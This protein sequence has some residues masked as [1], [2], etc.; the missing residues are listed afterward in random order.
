MIEPGSGKQMQSMNG[1]YK[2]SS[3]F[4]PQSSQEAMRTSN[5]G[6]VELTDKLLETFKPALVFKNFV[7][8]IY[9]F[10][11]KLDN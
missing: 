6:E 10:N 5:R 4:D 7:S 11:K 9:A 8:L 1:P 2:P 3:N